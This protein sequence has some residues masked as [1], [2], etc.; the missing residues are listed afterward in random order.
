MSV[1]AQDK[2]NGGEG[3]KGT[4]FGPYRLDGAL[5]ACS[6]ATAGCAFSAGAVRG[7]EHHSGAEA[8]QT[9]A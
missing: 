8:G 2:L 1:L 6:G 3:A 5:A 7:Q 4:V 9:A